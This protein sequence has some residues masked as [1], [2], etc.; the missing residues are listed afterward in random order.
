MGMLTSTT[1]LEKRH[2]LISTE[3]VTLLHY[4]Y[5][6]EKNPIKPKSSNGFTCC[7][8]CPQN[9]S[10]LVKLLPD[11]TS[12]SATLGT[13][14]TR[15][16]HYLFNTQKDSTVRSNQ[17]QK[18]QLVQVTQQKREQKQALSRTNGHIS[19]RTIHKLFQNQLSAYPISATRAH[20]RIHNKYSYLAL[21]HLSTASNRR[22]PCI[23]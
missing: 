11:E 6:R 10:Q 8:K 4:R 2:H 16:C 20:C 19:C 14:G 3:S 23:P 9:P 12:F 17:K 1:G 5:W 15:V 22:D 21:S 18:K 7:V 13:K